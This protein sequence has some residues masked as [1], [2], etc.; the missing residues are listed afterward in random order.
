MACCQAARAPSTSPCS[1]SSTPRLNIAA[2]NPH[3]AGH[4]VWRV[5]VRDRQMGAGHRALDADLMAGV[6]RHPRRTPALHA[7]DIELGQ[8]SYR[9]HGASLS[10][11][12]GLPR[13]DGGT[14][15]GRGPR[16]Q[17]ITEADRAVTYGSAPLVL[18]S[19]SL[20]WTPAPPVYGQVGSEFGYSSL[21][22]SPHNA[23]DGT[24]ISSAALPITTTVACSL[25]R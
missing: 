14:G 10:R 18:L 15:R 23:F 12:R 5:P 25:G 8:C 6:L 4:V 9:R 19:G 16:L 21:T 7:R 3:P 22:I 11:P 17:V 1:A 20:V 2:E 13:A 24:A